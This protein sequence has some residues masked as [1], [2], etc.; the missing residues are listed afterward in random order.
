MNTKK[1][2]I[3]PYI[4][5]SVPEIK[6]KMMQEIGIND[7]EELYADIPDFLRFKGSMDL[8]DPLLSEYDL[9]RHVN[10]ILSRN[11]TCQE[12]ISF[13]G[14]GCWQHYVPAICDEINQRSEFLT[15][16][17]GEPYEDH[18]RFHALF[19]YASMMGEL[20]EM[21]VVNVPTYD[22][23]QAASTALQMASR[24][25][26]RT[27]I[28]ISDV[29]S[30]E[31]LLIIR[32]YCNPLLKIKTMKTDYEN[33]KINLGDFED[34]ISNKTAGV[35]FENP[36]YFGCIEDQGSK[37]SSITHENGALCIVG[38]DP[39]S[40]GVLAPP[41][42]YGADIVCGDIQGL[43]MHMQYGGG[44]AGYIATHDEEKFVMEYPSRL[45]GIIPTVAKG[46]YGFGDVTYDRTSFSKRE[47]GKEFIGTATALWGITAGVYLA[48]LGPI[49]MQELGK[50]ILQKSQYAMQRLS[51]IDGITIPFNKTAH[52]KEFVVDF[53]RTRKKVSEI[54]ELL[55]KKKIFGGKDLS[56]EFPNLKE[57][58]LFCVT[59]VHKKDDID[60][61][62]L[63]LEEILH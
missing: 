7:I 16:Y 61:L 44:H 17:A 3:H 10:E 47:K 6:E 57:S 43:G 23:G 4:P 8:P 32:N 11:T 63:G 30:P 55:V 41:S 26:D 49:G 39:I 40:L 28:L 62:V 51:R 9:K 34:S 60:K 38:A 33:G 37:I 18:G 14:G 20:L 21:D 19:E 29:I 36:S 5:N 52:F 42:N 50:L 46:E 48:L 1:S 25:T 27:E 35:Y 12:S 54:N 2:F 45:F 56:Q 53:D 15:A 31:R 22:W 24:I 58:A 59:E 13:L